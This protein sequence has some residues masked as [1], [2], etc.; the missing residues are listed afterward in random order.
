MAQPDWDEIRAYVAGEEDTA[1]GEDAEED[2]GEGEGGREG[3]GEDEAEGEPSGAPETA[4]YSA[5]LDKVADAAP[6]T[7]RAAALSNPVTT[8]AG[9][10]DTLHGL[11]ARPGSVL[12]LVFVLLFF[13][14]AIVPVNG[15]ATRFELIWRALT[16]GAALPPSLSRQQLAAEYADI[17]EQQQ[18]DET[19]SSAIWGGVWGVA[20]MLG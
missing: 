2:D 17:A 9:W 12:P 10:L 7:V 14:F 18:Q 20:G 4:P 15:G 19:I 3:E 8:V 11:A 13:I 5:A 6:D 1:E 16:G